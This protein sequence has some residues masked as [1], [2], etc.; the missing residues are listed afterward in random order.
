VLKQTHQYLSQLTLSLIFDIYRF[1]IFYFEYVEI[2]LLKKV[3]FMI[4]VRFFR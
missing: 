3:S 2:N 1:N 4:I